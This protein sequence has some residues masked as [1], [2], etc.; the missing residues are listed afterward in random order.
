MTS[1]IYISKLKIKHSSILLFSD[2]SEISHN[3]QA[4]I[5]FQNTWLSFT[6]PVTCTSSG[7]QLIC[8]IDTDVLEDYDGDWE[9]ILQDP[10]SDTVYIPVLNSRVRLTLLLGRHF[11]RKK[12][13][14][15]FPMGGNTEFFVYKPYVFFLYKASKQFINSEGA[16]FFDS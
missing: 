16:Q 2:C 7:R 3:L 1:Q 5:H 10:A 8:S 15:F 12:E 6:H 4:E 14:V 11:I 13:T 9:L